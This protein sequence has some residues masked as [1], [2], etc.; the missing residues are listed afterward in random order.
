MQR[1]HVNLMNAR[2]KFTHA[3]WLHGSASWGE[4]AHVIFLNKRDTMC[5][6]VSRTRFLRRR[7]E[8]ATNA[9]GILAH[10]FL[11]C[12]SMVA[13]FSFL[14]CCLFDAPFVSHSFNVTTP[15]GRTSRDWWAVIL[16]S[17]CRTAWG[18]LRTR[19]WRPSRGIRT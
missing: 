2:K 3:G 11:E 17:W 18:A 7:G 19:S 8:A 5:G 4:E 12:H 13:L 16:T 14:A 15:P 9:L 10:V 1:T 6:W